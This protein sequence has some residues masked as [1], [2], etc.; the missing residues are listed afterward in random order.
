MKESYTRITR[1]EHNLATLKLSNITS[2]H[3]GK[4]KCEASTGIEVVSTEVNVEVIS[5]DPKEY[6]WELHDNVSH[7]YSCFSQ[8]IFIYEIYIKLF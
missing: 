1:D 8:V 4:Y 3:N 2:Q 5:E 7:N 6:K